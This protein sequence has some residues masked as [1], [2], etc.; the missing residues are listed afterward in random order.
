MFYNE[1]DFDTEVFGVCRQVSLEG[2]IVSQ[3]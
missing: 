1:G 2:K 3:L